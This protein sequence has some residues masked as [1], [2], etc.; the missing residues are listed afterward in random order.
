MFRCG[1]GEKFSISYIAVPSFSLRAKIEML[2]VRKYRQHKEV[3]FGD[4]T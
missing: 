3:I 1:F 4:N 2:E